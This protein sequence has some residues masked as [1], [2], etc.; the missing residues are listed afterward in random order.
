REGVRDLVQAVFIRDVLDRHHPGLDSQAEVRAGIAVGDRVDVERV[1]LLPAR[2]ELLEGVD[3][4]PAGRAGVEVIE[5]PRRLS[6]GTDGGPHLGH[7]RDRVAGRRPRS[8]PR[9][10]TPKRSA[11]PGPVWARTWLSATLDRLP[12]TC[13]APCRGLHMGEPLEV[14]PAPVR[15]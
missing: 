7:W 9:V 1:D 10:P 15:R 2:G 14:E 8:A 11:R 5:H 3:D 6:G 12:G 13:R 4:P